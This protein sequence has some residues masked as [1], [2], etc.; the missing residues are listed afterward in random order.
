MP[1]GELAE[2]SGIVT[3]EGEIIGVN[4][5]RELK[6]GET[7]LTSFALGDDSSTIYCKAFYNYRMKRAGF[8]E[9][10]QPPT[11]EEKKRVNEQTALIKNGARVRLRGECRQDAFLGEL[12][13]SVRDMQ[14]VPP[15]TSGR[16]RRPRATSAS[17]C[18]CTAT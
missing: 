16:T 15:S 14:T 13:I 8:G 7:V 4:E 10:P 1:I 6:G 18:I 9:T 2:D 3:V 12:S 11:A 5:P 17:S